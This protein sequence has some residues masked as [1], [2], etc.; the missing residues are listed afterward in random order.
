MR[1]YSLNHRTKYLFRYLVTLAYKYPSQ[2][3][4]RRHL[5]AQYSFVH[6]AHVIDYITQSHASTTSKEITEQDKVTVNGTARGMPAQMDKP[7]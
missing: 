4:S 1:G 7:L 3:F 2:H 6:K 5:A